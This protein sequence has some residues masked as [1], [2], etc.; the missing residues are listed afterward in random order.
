ML[1]SYRRLV[2]MPARISFAWPQSSNNRLITNIFPK[3]NVI[4]CFYI[5]IS[6]LNLSRVSQNEH[7][8]AKNNIIAWPRIGTSAKNMQPYF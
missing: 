6:C 8:D 7:S 4:S 5:D 2:C 1:H 3:V